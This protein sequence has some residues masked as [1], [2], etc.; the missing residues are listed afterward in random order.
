MSTLEAR[1]AELRRDVDWSTQ[2]T[3][4]VI[5]GCATLTALYQCHYDAGTLAQFPAAALPVLL[6]ALNT[7]IGATLAAPALSAAQSALVAVISDA[8][9]RTLGAEVAGNVALHT[10]GGAGPLV[11]LATYLTP[12]MW[13]GSTLLA[14]VLSCCG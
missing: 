5:I 13:W 3:R 9:S 11:D 4:I 6:S 10:I 1:V 12:T 7:A 14:L 8:L 2:A